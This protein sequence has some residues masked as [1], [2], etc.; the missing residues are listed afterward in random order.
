MATRIG[1]STSIPTTAFVTVMTTGTAITSTTIRTHTR[2]TNRKP[3]AFALSLVLG[4][5]A[6]SAVASAVARDRPPFFVATIVAAPVAATIAGALALRALRL[7]VF[8]IGS[9]R[10]ALRRGWPVWLGAIVIAVAFAHARLPPRSPA[11][12]LFLVEGV[13]FVPLAEE[14]AFRGALQ[15]ALAATALGERLVGI[16][17]R[18]STL[19]AAA[20]FGLARLALLADGVPLDATLVE[21]VSA[22]ALGLVAGYVYQRTGNLWYGIVLHAL[23]NLGGA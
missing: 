22:L 23:G 8:S 3:L 14:F 20:I 18:A 19:V 4:D 11:S 17:M 1:T 16:G 7:V 13:V 5:V 10:T 12:W 21:V 15:T 6:L 2:T 9:L